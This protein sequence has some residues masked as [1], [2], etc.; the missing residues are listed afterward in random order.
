MP[1]CYMMVGIPYSGK[2]TFIKNY[3]KDFD[4][5]LLSTDDYIE[6]VAS[7]DGKS[8]T[9]TFTHVYAR[10]SE[11]MYKQLQFALSNSLDIVWDQTNLTKKSRRQKLSLLPSTYTKIGC[12]FEIPEYEELLS[13][14][15]LRKEKIIHLDVIENMKKTFEFPSLEEGFDEIYKVKFKYSLEKFS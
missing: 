13:R 9:D 2:S 14:R 11:F 3:F 10:A 5:V 1:K 6:T 8:Y 15:E 12:V 4:Y 7:Q